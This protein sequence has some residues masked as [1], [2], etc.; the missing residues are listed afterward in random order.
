MLLPLPFPGYMLRILL[1]VYIAEFRGKNKNIRVQII[2]SNFIKIKL[3]KNSTSQRFLLHNQSFSTVSPAL[4]HQT[5]PC[6]EQ[7]KN[8]RILS[9]TNTI[10][11]TGCHNKHGI[12]DDFYTAFQ[13]ISSYL[14]LFQVISSNF[15]KFQVISSNFK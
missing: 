7:K 2:F 8:I 3:F 13:V 4:P 5:L 14:K 12:S 9:F 10:Y 11:Y 6:L 15:K 1:W